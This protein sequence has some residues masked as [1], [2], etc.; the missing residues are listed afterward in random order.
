LL[1]A[2]IALVAAM[3]ALGAVNR[4]RYVPSLQVQAGHPPPR[5]RLPLPGFLRP[6]GTSASA[7]HF[8]RSLQAET[9]LLLVILGVAAALSQEMPAAHGEHHAPAH[10]ARA[11]AQ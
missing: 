2:K 3:I 8:L 6:T 4:Y 10:Q 1:V 5:T 7:R 11:A 9:L